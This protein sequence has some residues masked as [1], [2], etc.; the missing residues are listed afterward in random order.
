MACEMAGVGVK[1]SFS[2]NDGL[3]F[4]GGEN[5]ERG[6]LRRSRQR[7][8][9]LAHVERAVDPLAATVLADRL[10]DGQDVRFG[11]G[12]AQR[13]AAMPAGSEDDQSDW[14]RSTSGRLLV[15][16]ALQARARSTRISFGAGLP[17]SG[18]TLVW[19][20]SSSHVAHDC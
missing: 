1:P 14:D 12:A 18:D 8:R 9:V 10:R 19:V 13:R 16:V 3:D 4:V 6:A 15:I 17:A 5:L 11:E 20:L 2:L 7:V